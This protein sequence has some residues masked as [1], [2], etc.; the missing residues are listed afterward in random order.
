MKLLDDPRLSQ[1]K[2]IV[3]RVR[4]ES[5]Q[6]NVQLTTLKSKQRG[7]RSNLFQ[8][9]TPQS[10]PNPSSGKRLKLADSATNHFKVPRIIVQSYAF[11]DEFE[12][13]SWEKP[14]TQ[15]NSS[16]GYVSPVTPSTLLTNQ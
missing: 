9:D 4:S 6:S 16:S 13:V 12:A 5:G 8:V 2:E 3:Y 14:S 1:F 10:S 15:N 7:R 11:D